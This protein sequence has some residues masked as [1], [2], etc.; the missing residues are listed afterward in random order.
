MQLKKALLLLAAATCAFSSD[1]QFHY[2]SS[3]RAADT[4]PAPVP[5]PDEA[6]FR[7]G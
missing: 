1:A 5:S 4:V 2:R 3:A 6:H 7:V